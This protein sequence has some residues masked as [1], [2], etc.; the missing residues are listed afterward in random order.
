MI[1]EKTLKKYHQ[2]KGACALIDDPWWYVDIAFFGEGAHVEAI[3]DGTYI[4]PEKTNQVVNTL[5][6]RLQRPNNFSN[7]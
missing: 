6:I 2:T 4:L 3:T 7:K 5:L 1:I